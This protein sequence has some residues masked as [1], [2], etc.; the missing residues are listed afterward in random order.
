MACGDVIYIMPEQTACND[1]IINSP[2]GYHYV[3]GM[4]LFDDI[5]GTQFEWNI[6][7]P[8]FILLADPYH[9]HPLRLCWKDSVPI[10][11]DNVWQNRCDIKKR[12][13]SHEVIFPDSRQ[14][15]GT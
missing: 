15:Y 2:C 7:S 13:I 6:N 5:I 14:G 1:F 12:M 3:I 10:V 4:Q 9:F 8:D 11:C